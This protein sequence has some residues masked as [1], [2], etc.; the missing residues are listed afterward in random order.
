MA[1]AAT[2]DGSHSN[3]PFFFFYPPQQPGT[4]GFP[5]AKRATSVAYNAFVGY[6]PV[7]NPVQ[8]YRGTVALI[9][10]FGDISQT[11]S[12]GGLW[13]SANTSI[14]G[15]LAFGHVDVA[16]RRRLASIGAED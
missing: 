7:G 9:A 15:Q 16:E 3:V 1:F 6:C 10:G 8:D 4:Q 5:V 2:Y 13:L 11:F 14:I 12:F